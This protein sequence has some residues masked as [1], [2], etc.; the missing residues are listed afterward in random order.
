MVDFEVRL[1]LNANLDKIAEG[2]EVHKNINEITRLLTEN[3]ETVDSNARF[4]KSRK[5][6]RF[7]G[8][9][10]DFLN[11][12]QIGNYRVERNNKKNSKIIYFIKPNWTIRFNFKKGKYE[13]KDTL[14]S[15]LASGEKYNESEAR[16]V[17]GSVMLDTLQG[18]DASRDIN[19]ILLGGKSQSL[20]SYFLERVDII[21][22]SP[23]R[24][25]GITLPFE[26]RKRKTLVEYEH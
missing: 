10:L 4:R 3:A 15:M 24:F 11:L 5:E 21:K 7:L 25:M 20:E 8:E 18:N 23:V 17:M 2:I 9:Q 16:E 12:E 19:E 13:P 6:G 22:E 1:L 14:K 26:Y